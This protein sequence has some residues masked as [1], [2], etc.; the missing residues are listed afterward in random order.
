MYFFFFMVYCKSSFKLSPANATIPYIM[1]NRDE[2]LS[3]MK[4]EGQRGKK[5]YCLLFASFLP[6]I[7]KVKSTILT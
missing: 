3:K 2:G 4:T 5:I 6:F 7:L 1:L